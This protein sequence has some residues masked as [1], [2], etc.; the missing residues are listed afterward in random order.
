MK[1]KKYRYLYKLTLPETGEFYYGSRSCKC[2]PEEDVNY[3]GSMVKWK[4][5]KSKLVK[6][7]F[8]LDINTLEELMEC[9]AELIRPDFKHPLNRNYR[10]PNGRFKNSGGYHLT[11]AQKKNLSEKNKG[12]PRSKEICEK[13][14][15]SNKGKHNNYKHSFEICKQISLKKIGRVP[16]DEEKRKIAIA[17]TG[18]RRSD[19]TKQKMS[20]AQKGKKISEEHKEKIRIS[21]RNR[22][23]VS[24]ETREKLSKIWKGKKRLQFTEEHLLKLSESHKNHIHSEEQKKKISD[25]LKETWRLKKIKKELGG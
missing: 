21:N 23:P 11:D 3:K 5:D 12:K 15:Q 20:I 16:S 19:E 4:P 1:E 8:L 22:Q 6:E 9:E 18:I 17:L 24:L 14:S 10:I 7:I 2:L 25:S 13:I